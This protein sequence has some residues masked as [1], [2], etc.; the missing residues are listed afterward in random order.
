MGLLWLVRLRWAAP[1]AGE[2]ALEMLAIGLAG[3]LV[4][5]VTAPAQAAQPSRLG[6][7]HLN[8]APAPAP[9]DAI[10]QTLTWRGRGLGAAPVEAYAVDIQIDKVR[11]EAQRLAPHDLIEARWSGY[12]VVTP[13]MEQLAR[14]L[15]LIS[16]REQLDRLDEVRLAFDAVAA[17][18]DPNPAPLYPLETLAGQ[19]AGP[20][21]RTILAAALL[22]ALGYRPALLRAGERTALAIAGA[23]PLPELFLQVEGE[24]AVFAEFRPEGYSFGDVPDRDRA[25]SWHVVP[26][27][28]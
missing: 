18:G 21:A 8:A 1:M 4:A 28:K 22:Q 11:L 23:A 15:R 6:L 17:S 25:V 3:M 9:A 14:D 5:G 24:P 20:G 26:L 10:T 19:Q 12:C 7:P 2:V 16:E 13:E 27:R